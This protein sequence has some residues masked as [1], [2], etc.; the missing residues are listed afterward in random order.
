VGSDRFGAALEGP[1]VRAVDHRSRHVELVGRPY[2]AQQYFVQSLHALASF[3]SRRRQ[4]VIPD[5]NPNS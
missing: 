5:P 3:Q 1:D 2:F 4:Q